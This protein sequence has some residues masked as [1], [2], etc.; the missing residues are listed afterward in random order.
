MRLPWFWNIQFSEKSYLY[1]YYFNMKYQNDKSKKNV[2]LIKTYWRSWFFYR[3]FHR[4]LWSF[5]KRK[6]IFV[7]VALQFQIV[8]Q[9]KNILFNAYM[10]VTNVQRKFNCFHYRSFTANN[11]GCAC[12]CVCQHQQSNLLKVNIVC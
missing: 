5:A 12:M 1:I 6:A 10:R 4:M 3:A 11:V 7:H 9:R 8:H 2:F